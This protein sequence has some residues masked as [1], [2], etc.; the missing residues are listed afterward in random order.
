VNARSFIILAALV[1]YSGQ[2]WAGPWQQ[3][4]STRFST[5]YDSNPNMIPAYQVGIWRA[6]IV[7]S[8]RLNRTGDANSVNAGASLN[9][10]R[11]SNQALSQDRNDPSVFLDGRQQSDAGEFGL[12]AKYAEVSTRISEFDNAGPFMADSTRA[13]HTISGSWNKALTER[14][15]LSAD[16]SYQG[17]YYSGGPYVNY[18]NQTVGMAFNYAWSEQISSFLRLSNNKYVPASGAP[19]SRL[20]SETLGLNW[21]VADS[22]EGS[23][24]AGRNRLDNGQASRQGSVEVKYAGDRTG[25][26]FNASR[27]ITPTGYGGF[28]ATDQANGNWSYALSERS[29]TGMDL[30]WRKSHYVSN[31][32]T[33][34]RAGVWIQRE[35]SSRWIM[36]MNYLRKLSEQSGLGI[37]S[38]NILGIAFTYTHADF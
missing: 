19:S 11:S 4:W 5:E 1:F 34:S 23:F 10:E 27:Q 2:G 13:S 17:V 9:I 33:D 32:I 24:Q 14:S 25:L 21:K 16:G 30:W 36:R 6:M 3:V 18:A 22:L 7:P 20:A 35:L 8:Y 15:T 12:S 28:V 31:M 37:A 29:T 38:S 26:A